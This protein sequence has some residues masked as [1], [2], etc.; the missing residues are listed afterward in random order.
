MQLFKAIYFLFS[1]S[2]LRYQ[3]F[4]LLFYAALEPLLFHPR[5][6]VFFPFATLSYSKSI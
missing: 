5:A 6:I 1:K 2:K 4:G 3:I